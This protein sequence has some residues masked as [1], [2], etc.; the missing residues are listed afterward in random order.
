VRVWGCV[1]VWVSACECERER[2]WVSVQMC[3][4]VCECEFECVRECVC[5][6]ECVCVIV[7]CVIVWASV[8]VSDVWVVC[9]SVCVLYVSV[10]VRAR[11]CVSDSVCVSVG[12]VCARVCE[13]ERV[14]VSV[15]VSCVIVC[16]CVSVSCVSMCVLHYLWIWRWQV[17]RILNTRDSCEINVTH[18]LYGNEEYQQTVNNLSNRIHSL[19]V[20][21]LKFPTNQYHRK[22]QERRM[23]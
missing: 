17:T 6:C 9:V 18:S 23:W 10:L 15:W 22:W 19:R 14:G 20:Q 13:W 21:S 4:R 16:D 5:G 1:S 3:A 8:W 7:W 11:E 12:D 2:V